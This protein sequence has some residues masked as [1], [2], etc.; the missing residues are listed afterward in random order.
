MIRR[1]Q[2]VQNL[3]K[4]SFTTNPTPLVKEYENEHMLFSFSIIIGNKEEGKV[5]IWWK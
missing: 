3:T 5:S 2:S 1:I 4:K